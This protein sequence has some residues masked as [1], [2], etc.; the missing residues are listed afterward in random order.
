MRIQ[1]ADNMHEEI[2]GALDPCPDRD[3]IL[4]WR[5]HDFWEPNRNE[6]TIWS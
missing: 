5:N 2:L 4:S 3:D 6:K 1:L